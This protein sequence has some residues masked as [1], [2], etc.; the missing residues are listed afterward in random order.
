MYICIYVDVCMRHARAPLPRT[1]PCIYSMSAMRSSAMPACPCAV[2][3]SAVYIYIY[4]YMHMKIYTYISVY[5]YVYIY[6]IYVY[7]YMYT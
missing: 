1:V 6:Y 5:V 7:I 4:I 2:Y 3:I